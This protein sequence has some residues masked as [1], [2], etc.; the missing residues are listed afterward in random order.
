MLTILPAARLL[1][2]RLRILIK[3]MRSGG[4]YSVRLSSGSSIPLIGING[5]R[6]KFSKHWASSQSS[7]LLFSI[8]THYQED[9]G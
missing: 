7:K 5:G 1:W 8:L 2:P 9:L 6:T 4:R 3:E